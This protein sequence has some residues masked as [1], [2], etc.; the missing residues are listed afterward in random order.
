MSHPSSGTSPASHSSPFISSKDA[1]QFW[2]DLRPTKFPAKLRANDNTLL[3]ELRR[4]AQVASVLPTSTSFYQEAFHNTIRSKSRKV[5]S[6]FHCTWNLSNHYHRS[7]SSGK[8]PEAHKPLT[9]TGNSILDFIRS[10]EI[11]K[12]APFEKVFPGTSFPYVTLVHGQPRIDKT[13]FNSLL[14]SLIRK[15]K[16]LSEIKSLKLKT[17]PKPVTLAL[18]RFVNATILDHLTKKKNAASKAASPQK[19]KSE[20][21]AAKKASPL[22]SL[23]SPAQIEKV[24]PPPKSTLTKSAKRRARKASAKAKTLLTGFEEPAP[25]KANPGNEIS[26]PAPITTAISRNVPHTTMQYAHSL[27]LDRYDEISHSTS[28][29]F[30]K[31]EKDTLAYFGIASDRTLQRHEILLSSHTLYDIY[32]CYECNQFATE[33]CSRSTTSNVSFTAPAAPSTT[34]SPLNEKNLYPVRVASLML[35]NLTL[36]MTS[37]RFS[38]T[39]GKLTSSDSEILS[40][41]RFVRELPTPQ[42]FNVLPE[43]GYLPLVTAL[44]ATFPNSSRI[45]Q[46]TFENIET[47]DHNHNVVATPRS[48]IT[49]KNLVSNDFSRVVRVLTSCVDA[50]KY[51]IRLD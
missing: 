30:P 5:V 12:T 25:R 44:N 43:T 47:F 49:S 21:T 40:A 33:A 10:H 51:G 18:T 23:T 22:S 50:F 9:N 11:L 41:R 42:E 8:S 28:D 39:T 31:F 13:I 7:P 37:L 19:G 27:K 2:K 32:F 45:H 16:S 46:Y 14:V 36:L 17:L 26:T 4:L 24:S 48:E 20:K 15:V 1:E 35:K 29:L 38:P 34:A 6:F 3:P